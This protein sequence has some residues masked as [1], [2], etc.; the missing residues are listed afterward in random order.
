MNGFWWHKVV[1]EKGPYQPQDPYLLVD[2]KKGKDEKDEDK[3]GKER[4]LVS[5]VNSSSTFLASHG[6]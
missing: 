6:S 1:K 4:V 2:V 3:I 5:T